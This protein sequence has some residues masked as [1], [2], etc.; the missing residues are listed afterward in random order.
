MSSK[1][2]REHQASAQQSTH[3]YNN[4]HKPRRTLADPKAEAKAKRD[5]ISRGRNLAKQIQ[6]HSKM[7]RSSGEAIAQPSILVDLAEEE[8]LVKFLNLW[9]EH[10]PGFGITKKRERTEREMKMEWRTRLTSRKKELGLIVDEPNEKTGKSIK[11]SKKSKITSNKLSGNSQQKS[12]GENKKGLQSSGGG[13][14]AASKA[15]AK[16]AAK[17]RKVEMEKLRLETVARYKQ[18][19]Q[20]RNSAAI[21]KKR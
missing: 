7:A 3:K 18:L 2:P 12:S 15:A 4:K 19:K 1:R 20:K 13:A 8:F 5:E 17:A 21:A 9:D 11:R 10:V 6:V 14:S 16:V